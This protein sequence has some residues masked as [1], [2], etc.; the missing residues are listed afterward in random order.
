MSETIGDNCIG[1]TEFVKMMNEAGHPITKG[2]VS[3]A[4][5]SGRIP[6][7]RD[8][9]GNPLFDFVEARDAYL[10]GRT[11][12]IIGA[13][14]RDTMRGGG[15]SLTSVPNDLMEAKAANERLRHARDLSEFAVSVGALVTA[16][17]LSRAVTDAVTT[18]R[19]VMRASLDELAPD[20][21]AMTDAQVIARRVHKR[22]TD[23]LARFADAL[24][25]QLFKPDHVEVEEES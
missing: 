13:A 17:D 9:R 24:R 25:G 20:V 14:V 7:V 15:A 16:A 1:V 6:C 23:V 10:S 2:T 8:E 3:K 11:P 12:K 4:A 5:R 21:A 22:D 19:E 18:L